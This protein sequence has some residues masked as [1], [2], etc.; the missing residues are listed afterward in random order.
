MRR[1]A[2]PPLPGHFN[3]VRQ[4]II[5]FDGNRNVTSLATG[6]YRDPCQEGLVIGMDGG[7]ELKV[8]GWHPIWTCVDGVFAYRTSSEIRNL[9]SNKTDVWLPQMIGFPQWQD[10]PHPPSVAGVPITRDVAYLI[11]L[12]TGDGC[13]TPAAL[14]KGNVLFSSNDQSV[15]DDL[16]QIIKTWIPNHTIKRRGQTCD[17]EIRG[18]ALRNLAVALKLD[19]YSHLKTVP[20]V[21]IESSKPTVRAYLQGLFDTDGCA[22]GNGQVQLATTSEALA[23]DVQQLLFGFGISARIVFRPN[24]FKGCWTVHL[25]GANA[26]GFYEDIG[27]RLA[28]KQDRRSLLSEDRKTLLQDYPPCLRPHLKRLYYSRFDRGAPRNLQRRSLKSKAKGRTHFDNYARGSFGLPARDFAA[29]MAYSAATVDDP[30]W[31]YWLGGEGRWV[32]V[33]SVKECK[34]DLY[35]VSVPGLH[36]F[37]AGGTV[38]HNTWAVMHKVVRHLWE[39]PQARVGIFAKTI[40]NAKE[41]GVWEDLISYAMPEW[42]E[43][44]LEGISPDVHLHY[45]MEPTVNGATRTSTFKIQNYWGSESEIKLFSL[46]FDGE[47]E[48]K[49]KGTRFSMLWFSELT[50]FEDRKVYVVSKQQLRMPHLRDDQHMWIADTNPSD[51]GE[52]SW[53]YQIWY[54]ERTQSEFPEWVVTEEDRKAFLNAQRELQLVEIMLDDN[55]F[56]SEQRKMEIKA[57]HAYD[58]DLYD[59]SVLGKW[60][61][62][63]TKNRLLASYFKPNIHVSGDASSVREDEWEVALPSEGCFELVTGWD[64]G[65]TSHSAHI[66]EKTLVG[67][68]AIWTIL[69]ELVVVEEQMSIEEFVGLFMQKMK[70]V[71]DAAAFAAGKVRQIAWRHYSDDSINRYRSAVDDLDRNLVFKASKGTIELMG[72]PKPDGS[73]MSRVSLARRLLYEQRLRVSAQCLATIEMFKRLKKGSKKSEPVM[74]DVHKHPFD[75]VTYPIIMECSIDAAIPDKAMTVPKGQIISLDLG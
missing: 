10:N 44:N 61:A 9:L 20:D 26:L 52:D 75:S 25:Y 46:D 53:I 58:K 8:S 38:N 37:I 65:D 51:E 45:T 35:D 67:D 43:A 33:L 36:N 19:C 34:V 57:D 5:S 7:A 40:K 2:E 63:G 16:A 56:I 6:F 28:R 69:D 47:V 66:L 54:K 15:L 3:A 27:F 22:T 32:K 14:K 23:R 49:V 17:Y 60:V 64:L 31:A 41:G 39:T 42:L 48:A 72:V 68:K 55:E 71:T 30:A 4:P 74:R 70:W 50:N 29:F 24:Q 13:M 12:L 59:R 11:G 21:I 1:F 62:G 73:V 18:V